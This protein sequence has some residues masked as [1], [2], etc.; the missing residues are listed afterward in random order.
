MKLRAL[1]CCAALAAAV[2]PLARPAGALEGDYEFAVTR[3]AVKFT[4]RVSSQDA[5]PGDRFTFDTTSSAVVDARFLPTGTHGH[6]V[7]TAARAARGSE[8]GV[9]TLEARSLDP[10]EGNPIAVGLDSRSL[11]GPAATASPGAGAGRGNVAYA[12]GTPFIVVA[13]PP[14]SPVGSAAP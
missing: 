14:P 5:K 11:P 8:P 7:V 4:A 6:G 9:L 12:A 1:A 10:A 13:P 2:P 3:I